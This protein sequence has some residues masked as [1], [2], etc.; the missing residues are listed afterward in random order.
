MSSFESAEM[1]YSL[2]GVLTEKQFCLLSTGSF[3]TLMEQVSALT[4][5][6]PT[7]ITTDVLDDSTYPAGRDPETV[8]RPPD[9]AYPWF[10]V[11]GEATPCKDAM[12]SLPLQIINSDKH[13]SVHS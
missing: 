2:L 1:K 5:I 8:R 3:N 7:G 6:S 10:L 9:D 4:R 13:F 12:S 11:V